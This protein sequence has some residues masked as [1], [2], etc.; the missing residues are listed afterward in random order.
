MRLFTKILLFFTGL[1]I[2]LSVATTYFGI[3]S[4]KQIAVKE[5]ERGL[6]SDMNVFTLAVERELYRIETTLTL[7]VMKDRFKKA[8]SE[9]DM[10]SLIQILNET[11]NESNMNILLLTDEK[12]RRIALAKKKLRGIPIVI[13][14]SPTEEI[15]RGFTTVQLGK[16]T[17][18]ALRIALPYKDRRGL[19]GMLLGFSTFDQNSPFLT[20]V[21]EILTRKREESVYISLFHNTKRVFTTVGVSDGT[22]GEDLPHAAT[23]ILYEKGRNYIGKTRIGKAGYFA[24]YA[25]ARYSQDDTKWAYG[26]AVSENIFFP[27]KK[28]LLFMFIGFS[29]LATSAVIG[30]AFL[31]TRGIDPSLVKIV[32]I[33]GKIEKGDMESRIDEREVKLNEFALI[34]SSINKMIERV[35][36]RETIIAENMNA[37]GRINRELEEKSNTIKEDRKRFLLILETMDDGLLTV[38]TEGTITYFNGAAEQITGTGKEAVIG[39]HYQGLF[40][41]LKIDG[42]RQEGSSAIVLEHAPSSRY[43][44]L[45]ISPFVLENEERGYIL[46]FHDISKEKRVEEFKADFVSSIA[47]DIK[48]F[49]MPVSGYLNRI[50]N[51][52]YGLLDEPVREKILSI[53]ENISKIHHLVENYLN[54]SIIESG[55]LEIT[56]QPADLPA[57]I[58]DIVRLYGSR[59]HYTGN[60]AVPFVLADIPYIERVLANLI[61][62]ALK[63]SPKGGLV[64]VSTRKDEEEVVTSVQ[65]EGVGIPVDEIPYIFDKY[66]RGGGRGE[67][68]TGLGL[69]IVKTIVEAH[70][71]SI[72]VESKPRR[73]TT[74]SFSLPLANLQTSG[75]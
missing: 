34:A 67:E 26:I 6:T 62:N 13:N 48:S 2:M 29:A 11:I 73:G 4:I 35:T 45:S 69:F 32:N 36:E 1:V 28:R 12:G 51:G 41:T 55:N 56:P 46:L 14:V 7:L 57:I 63:F 74:F 19:R 39:C 30:I 31:V 37:I 24:I 54:L 42:D 33:C 71:G 49:L 15:T 22:Y 43:L 47:H 58:L 59:V 61:V 40:P 65:D 44:K 8:M 38:N 9:G 50:L 3:D 66:R 10:P 52:K 72:W 21:S 20:N 17:P 16:A 25:P 18:T 64:R 53:E 23:E 60:R 27:Y 75:N 68:G 5:L 70:G